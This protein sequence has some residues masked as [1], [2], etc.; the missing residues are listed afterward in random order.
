MVN[1]CSRETTEMAPLFHNRGP[2]NCKNW[3]DRFRWLLIVWT[4]LN[5]VEVVLANESIFICRIPK[6]SYVL[7][8]MPPFCWLLWSN[9]TTAIK[10]VLCWKWVLIEAT[11]KTMVIHLHQAIK[12]IYEIG[13]AEPLKIW[14]LLSNLW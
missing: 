8:D 7:K 10:F 12:F 4:F 9:Y 11:L 14:S 13:K 6:L 2:L 5:F 1:P 3:K